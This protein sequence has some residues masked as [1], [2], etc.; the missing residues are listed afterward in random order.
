MVLPMCLETVHGDGALVW[1]NELPNRDHT[2][3]E[4][5]PV[6]VHGNSIGMTFNLETEKHNGGC[7]LVFW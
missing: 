7:Y 3:I 2:H 5:R 1:P 4:A 6:R